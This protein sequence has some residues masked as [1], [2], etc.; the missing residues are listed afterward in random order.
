MQSGRLWRGGKPGSAPAVSLKKKPVKALGKWWR[1]TAG[2]LLSGYERPSKAML[3]KR[4]A[5]VRQHL[6]ALLVATSKVT[7]QKQGLP[8]HAVGGRGCY[9]KLLIGALQRT[10]PQIGPY[11]VLSDGCPVI[12]AGELTER[13]ALR[14][15][16]IHLASVLALAESLPGNIQEVLIAGCW[17]NRRLQRCA[18]QASRH[19]E[20][21]ICL[22]VRPVGLF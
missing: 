19:F 6:E 18:R 21:L 16:A 8:L 10:W 22:L 17:D 5:E 11:Y 12:K 13:Y 1:R 14:V 15:D 7:T 20:L 3:K 2:D 9:Q 4:G